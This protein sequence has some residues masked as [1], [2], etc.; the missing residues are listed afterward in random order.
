MPTGYTAG[1]KPEGGVTFEQ[2]VMGCARAFGAL[3]TM[4]DDPADA[5]IPDEFKPDADHRDRIEAAEQR[6]LDI[7]AMPLDVAARH[8][9]ESHAEA[10]RR[11]ADRERE[12]A[13]QR[14]AYEAMLAKVRAWEP[15]TPDHQELRSFMLSQ[16]RE[17]IEFDCR[18]YEPPAAMSGADWH[19]FQ[20][21]EAERGLAYVR[22]EAAEDVE[23]ARQRTEWV[24][25]LRKSLRAPAG[26]S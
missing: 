18:V 14:A 20:M 11:H 5:A 15:P 16:I 12:A 19:R 3:V 13:A 23:R 6:L 1:I 10:M 25:A 21:R 24:R 26:A 4:R 9:A 7:T 2:F 22:N 8:A 17:S